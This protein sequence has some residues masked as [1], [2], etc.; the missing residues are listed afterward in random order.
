[1][2]GRYPLHAQAKES[3]GHSED[4][5]G[6]T[7]LYSPSRMSWT[8]DSTSKASSIDKEPTA[9]PIDDEL[10]PADGSEISGWAKACSA[11]V[12]NAS[13]MVK[14]PWIRRRNRKFVKRTSRDDDCIKHVSTLQ[15]CIIH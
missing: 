9:S 5:P 7:V 3:S 15:A 13:V 4:D 12:E 2:S 11:G 6:L 10:G 1:M 14:E 8:V